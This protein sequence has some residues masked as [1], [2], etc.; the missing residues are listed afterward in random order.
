[1]AMYGISCNQGIA[2]QVWYA[3]N[4]AV[5]GCLCELKRW[6]NKLHSIGRP[7]GYN[8][9]A[10]KSWLVVKE[11]TFQISAASFLGNWDSGYLR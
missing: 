2:K 3:D 4:A 6:W 5:G 1:M 11:M 10:S 7:F 9:N 8:V